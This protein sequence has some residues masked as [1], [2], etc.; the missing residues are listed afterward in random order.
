MTVQLQCVQPWLESGSH[1][2]RAASLI[3]IAVMVEGSSTYIKNKCVCVCVCVR[4]CVCVCVCVCVWFVA[5]S[6]DDICSV[7][8]F[9]VSLQPSSCSTADYL[10][11]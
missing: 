2:E 1:F 3:A 7:L 6:R 4:V 9:F 11:R 10:Q 8:C 5:Q